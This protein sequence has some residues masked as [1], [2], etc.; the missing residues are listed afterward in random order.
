MPASSKAGILKTNSFVS[1]AEPHLIVAVSVTDSA[2][3]ILITAPFGVTTCSLLE[4]QI[5]EVFPLSPV[6]ERL[7]ESP[8]V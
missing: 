1:V 5:I 6:V 8:S 4:V 7:T 2:F 3:G